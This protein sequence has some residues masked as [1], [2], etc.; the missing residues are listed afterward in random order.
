VVLRYTSHELLKTN[1]VRAC[2]AATYSSI[3]IVNGDGAPEPPVPNTITAVTSFCI[4]IMHR[5]NNTDFAM[6]H[7]DCSF[8]EDED[9]GVFMLRYLIGQII[10]HPTSNLWCLSSEASQ[11]ET[12]TKPNQSN[13]C[14][15]LT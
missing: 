1:E 13:S 10:C 4:D 8:L 2:T 7:W 15:F 5:T 6:L 11:Y 9:N 12:Q 14:S 3:L